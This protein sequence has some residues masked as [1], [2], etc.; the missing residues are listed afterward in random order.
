MRDRTK[1]VWIGVGITTVVMA[2]GGD[3]AVVDVG[4]AG[5]DGSP[6]DASITDTSLVDGG[7]TDALA[8]VTTDTPADTSAIGRTLDGGLCNGGVVAI[9]R[10]DP[11]FAAT[12]TKTPITI[13]GTG[14]LA[15]PAVYLRGTA[16][17]ASGAF[18]T[19]TQAAFIDSTSM[20][21]Q[22]PSLAV[23]T[24]EL[25][26]VD[27]NGCAGV[28]AG[29]KV[30][31]NPVPLVLTVSPATGTTQSDVPVTITGCHFPTA[32]GLA[33]VSSTNVVTAE[34]ASAATCTGATNVCADASPLCTMTGTVATAALATGAYLV[35]VTNVADAT[36]GEYASF[37]VT[38]PSAK[39]SGGFVPTSPLVTGR[40]SLGVVTGRVDDAN[41]FVYAIGGED[42]S[43]AALASVEV[44]Q[45]DR[46][47]KA[48]KWFVQRRA[49]TAPR[50]GLAVVRQGR[51]L[52]AIGG[53]SATN[54]TKGAAPTGAPL[55]TIER[56]KILDAANAPI[57]AD[58]IASTSSGTLA[59]GTYYYQVEA[60]MGAG[61]PDNPSGETVASGE[62]V[63]TL[64]AAGHVDLTWA[65][66]P[67]AVSYR[68]YRSKVADDPSGTEV[69]L[70]TV[71]G[72]GGATVGFTDTGAATPGT[73]LPVHLGA[74]GPWTQVATLA[75]AR[76]DTAATIAPDPTGTLH[77]IVAGGWGSCAGGAAAIMNCYES[78]TI[79]PDGSALGAPTLVADL[80][81][82][83]K[84]AR[85]RFGLAAMTKE[86]GPPGFADGGASTAAFVVASGGYGLGGNGETIEYAQVGA[87]TLGNW[88]LPGSGFGNE[89][90]GSQLLIVNGY[91]Y[92]LLGGTAPNYSQTS[93]LSSTATVTSTGDAS[94]PLV[95]D[96]GNWSNA[97]ANFATKIGR[98]G[99]GSESAHIYVVGGTT[100]DVDA[101]ATVYQIL[102]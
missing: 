52:Y 71:S 48:G 18:I 55:G 81:H 41:R 14:F 100:N 65:A 58:P 77:L 30:V 7:G 96:F 26:V 25:A 102:D 94:F 56:A 95:L 8:D 5:S 99:I 6:V 93:S 19:L 12:G 60:V 73:E 61:D 72:D 89:R 88:G 50:S 62:V 35:R 29:F 49:L 51:W 64:T 59:K 21:V 43:G 38:N 86:N 42:A 33:I 87:S 76:L 17:D 84:N 90:D 74:T 82:P 36:Y 27:P 79:T 45:L 69:L 80:T 75:S 53:T 70:A 13:T 92:A 54:G 32:P 24:Y 85:M 39:L 2:C 9:T 46:F 67:G 101:L 57:V 98:H 63:A 37:V 97:G 31:A 91:A 23:G 34:T 4:D 28:Y 78:T 47:G 83:M 44:A 16:G 22:V 11:P 10:V 68:V 3:D 1:L 40:R 15:T 20:T 66:V